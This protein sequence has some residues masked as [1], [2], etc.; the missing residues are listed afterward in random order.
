MEQLNFIGKDFGRGYVGSKDILINYSYQTKTNG[1]TAY[2]TF[3]NNCQMKICPTTSCVMYA[4][5]GT[6]IYFKEADVNHGYKIGTNKSDKSNNFYMSLKGSKNRVALDFAREHMGEYD[7]TFDSSVG[8]WMI[9]TG[10]SFTGKRG[11]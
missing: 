7:L 1:E 4:V 6:R 5:S 11:N 10:L 2:F 3:R 9:E 8:L